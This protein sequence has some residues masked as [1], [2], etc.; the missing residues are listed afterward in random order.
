MQFHCT[1]IM[2]GYFITA[3]VYI[4]DTYQFITG[5]AMPVD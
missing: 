2:N 4:A 1:G 3:D 5:F